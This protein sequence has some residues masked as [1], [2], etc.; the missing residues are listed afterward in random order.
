VLTFPESQTDRENEWLEGRK[1]VKTKPE[2]PPRPAYGPDVE[3]I[4]LLTNYGWVRI[5]Q[6]GKKNNPCLFVYNLE[7][8]KR[9]E[10]GHRDQVDGPLREKVVRMA[11]PNLRSSLPKDEEFATDFKTQL[12]SD[13][14]LSLNESSREGLLSLGRQHSHFVVEYLG[15]SEVY[16][17]AVKDYY[18]FDTPLASPPQGFAHQGS[19]TPTSDDEFPPPH[20][21]FIN[22]LNIILGH[23]AREKQNVLVV[24]GNRFFDPSL[25]DNR[26][27]LET[28][29][30][31]A[32]GYFHSIR[33]VT[34]RLLLNAN[35]IHAAFRYPVELRKVFE[36]HE[37]HI[38]QGNWTHKREMLKNILIG[39][40]VKVPVKRHNEADASLEE[41]T[42]RDVS[43]YGPGDPRHKW[44]VDGQDRTVLSHFKDSRSILPLS[45]SS[46]PPHDEFHYV[47]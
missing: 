14:E 20:N 47:C 12:V 26:H 17:Q 7:V 36:K 45:P 13:K 40:I 41:K 28:G 35:V 18:H 3:A 24:G 31:A 39:A 38:G 5:Q 30:I 9:D 2:M 19:S 11:I 43:E 21:Q 10:D 32:R 29:I 6:K 22:A 37:I 25:E 4:T 34:S 33:P 15:P 42:I 27:E 1:D 46:S 16:F 23:H 8:T 44:V